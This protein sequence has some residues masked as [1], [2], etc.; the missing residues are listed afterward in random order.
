MK[1]LYSLIRASMTSGMSLFKIKSKNNSKASKIVIPIVLSFLFMFAIW[2][3]ANLMF[4]KFAPLH[5]QYIVLSL[6]VFLTAIMTLVEGIYKTSSLLFNC[7]D[8]QLLLS[9]PISRRT[10]LFVRIFKFYAFELA[11]HSLFIIPLAVEQY[12]K[13]LAQSI[14]LLFTIRQAVPMYSQHALPPHLPGQSHHSVEH[15]ERGHILPA[16]ILTLFIF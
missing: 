2:S 10:V 3:N 14:S 1:K 15:R 6:F 12:I 9:L 11:F 16:T 5:L 13:C 8:D 7:K 4:E